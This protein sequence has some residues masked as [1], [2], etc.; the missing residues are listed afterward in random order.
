LAEGVK[1]TGMLQLPPATTDVP[2]LFV[3]A[4]FEALVPTIEIE[5]PVRVAPPVFESVTAIA[6]LVAP[7]AV[8]GNATDA[9]T[10][11]T[12]AAVPVPVSEAV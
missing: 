1:V 11:L 6:E 9:G 8:F 2:Q 4:K 3:C 10:K 12:A 5:M 7:T